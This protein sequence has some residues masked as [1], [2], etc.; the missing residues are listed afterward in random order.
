[1]SAAR[2]VARKILGVPWSETAPVRR[3]LN[4]AEAL[5]ELHAEQARAEERERFVKAQGAAA[6]LAPEVPHEVIAAW[7]ARELA[8]FQMVIDH[9]EKTYCY[10]SRGKV[11]KAQ[12]LPEVVIAIADDADSEELAGRR[13]AVMAAL[14]RGPGLEALKEEIEEALS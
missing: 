4:A 8:D 2:E 10:F 13:R 1:M 5:I 11:S 3:K 14:A 7:L 6:A 12:T 9:C